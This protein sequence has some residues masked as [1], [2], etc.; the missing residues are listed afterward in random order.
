V[1]IEDDREAMEDNNQ[2]DDD[3]DIVPVS[4]QEGEDLDENLD[5]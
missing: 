2:L 3:E 1:P 4:D 5:K